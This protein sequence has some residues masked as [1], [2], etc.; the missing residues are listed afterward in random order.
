M[1]NSG[2]RYSKKDYFIESEE[3]NSMPHRET[4]KI[5]RIQLNSQREI[6]K[7]RLYRGYER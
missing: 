3:L 2:N 4:V 7:C 6:K 5:I 1:R